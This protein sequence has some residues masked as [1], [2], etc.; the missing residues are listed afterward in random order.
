[1]PV[2]II[3]DHVLKGYDP[4]TLAAAVRAWRLSAPEQ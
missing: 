3:G 4:K 1:V 2:T